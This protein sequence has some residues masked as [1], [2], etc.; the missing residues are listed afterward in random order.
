MNDGMTIRWTMR[1]LGGL[2]SSYLGQLTS[3]RVMALLGSLQR[4]RTLDRTGKG[5]DI[6]GRAFEPYAES[7][8]PVRQARGAQTG[9][10]DLNLSGQMWAALQVDA[11]DGRATLSFQGDPAKRAHGHQMGYAPRGLPS[12]EFFGFGRGDV[13]ALED[14]LRRVL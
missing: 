3:P 8:V 1:G 12:R 4:T 13:A 6:E 9:H 7:Y 11:D 5:I 2:F 10:V 14:E